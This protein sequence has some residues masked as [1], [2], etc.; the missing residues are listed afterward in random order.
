MSSFHYKCHLFHDIGLVSDGGNLNVLTSG[1][2]FDISV[3]FDVSH[4]VSSVMKSLLSGVVFDVGVI[5][6]VG[7]NVSSVMLSVIIVGN[8]IFVIGCRL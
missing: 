7:R 4:N 2:I 5:F 6:V 1:V 3:I 8:V